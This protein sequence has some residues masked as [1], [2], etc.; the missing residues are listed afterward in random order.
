[1][2]ENEIIKL[3]ALEPTDIEIIYN[4]ENNTNIWNVSNT[5][6]PFAKHIIKEYIE[7][8]HLDIY[9]TKQL[10]LIIETNN[11]P[12]GTIDLFDFDPYN[13]RAGIGILIAEDKNKQ[14]GYATSALNLFIEYAF[15][16]LGL[17]QIYCNISESNSPSL[18]LFKN[19]KFEIIGN[20]KDCNKTVNGFENEYILQLINKQI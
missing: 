18:K 13:L 14:K 6:T 11:T 5:I 16:T 9:Q 2:L 3:R 12:I 7:S 1:M 8:A 4:W 17:H 19:A 20:K 10:R 15:N